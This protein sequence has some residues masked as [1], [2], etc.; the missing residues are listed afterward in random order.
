[1]VT[2]KF[3][4]LGLMVALAV[5]IFITPIFFQKERKGKSEGSAPRLMIRIRMYCFLAI[6]VV[7]L[8]LVLL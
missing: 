6:L 1:M 5:T 8:L 2:F 3:I 7:L 4:L